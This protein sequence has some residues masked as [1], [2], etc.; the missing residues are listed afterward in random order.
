VKVTT[1]KVVA[2][3]VVVDGG[4]PLPEGARVTVLVPSDRG[5]F[6]LSSEE[7]ADL[8]QVLTAADA[9]PSLPAEDLLRELGQR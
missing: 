3:R 5:G 7:E 1:G 8:R 6:E 9:E 2:G 4:D